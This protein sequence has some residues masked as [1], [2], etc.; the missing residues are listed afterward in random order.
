MC[1]N[2]MNLIFCYISKKLPNYIFLSIRQ[3]RLFNPKIN[4]Y[5]ITNA[6]N[7]DNFNKLNIK[8]IKINQLIKT[9]KHLNFSKNNCMK[10][11]KTQGVSNDFWSISIERF[12]YIE[13]L[14]IKNNLIN[15]IQIECDNLI[16]YD[17]SKIF[18][19]ITH[20]HMLCSDR[21]KTLSNA[22]T[23]FKNINAISKYTEFLTKN[24]NDF[25]KIWNLF[26]KFK[27]KKANKKTSTNDMTLSLLYYRMNKDEYQI[28]LWPNLPF[29]KPIFN[30]ES[31]RN[32][33]KFGVLF[34]GAQWGMNQGGWPKSV[35]G[36]NSK[37]G[38]GYKE[39]TWY[40][41]KMLISGDIKLIWGKDDKNR[42]VPYCL[43][44]KTNI[45][46]RIVNLHIHCK[47]CKKFI[48]F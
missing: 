5:L 33:K 8:I 15:I 23:Y 4:I 38:P 34:D 2:Y 31:N 9:E 7:I 6:N 13:E 45:K 32:F 40:I 21:E 10:S 41:G 1:I 26:D 48:S 11:V 24:C 37:Y 36:E 44:I 42:K 20:N 47:D 39:E 18:S 3:A 16:Y 25:G 14:I 43:N 29:E 19:K 12:F 22:I 17:F 35:V 28:E 46:T 30:E 27:I